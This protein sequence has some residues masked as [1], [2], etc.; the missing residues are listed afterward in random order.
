[1]N[2]NR[3]L[4]LD[5]DSGSGDTVA[6]AAAAAGY[7]TAS[8]R[9]VGQFLQYLQLWQPAFVMLDIGPQTDESMALLRHLWEVRSPALVVLMGRVADQ[10]R[11]H[12]LQHIGASHGLTMAGLMFK[13]LHQSE[14][15]RTLAGLRDDRHWL[16]EAAVMQALD[17]DEFLLEYQPLTD[18]RSG[19]IRS[20]E[21]LIRWR[22]PQRGR[23][24]PDQFIPFVE[25][26]RV[27]GPVTQWVAE[28]AIAQ[29]G[30]WSEM[31]LELNIAINASARNLSDDSLA[32]TILAACERAGIPPERVTLEITETAAM[33]RFEDAVATLSRLR[34]SGMHLAIDDFGTGYSSLAQ[35]RRL[36]FS[37]I[38]I[39]RSLVTNCQQ[40][41]SAL[42]I[43]STVVDLARSL[44]LRCIAEGVETKED[45]DAVGNL[46]CD[47]AQGY[48]ISRPLPA[49]Q[50][51][52]WLADWPVIPGP[53]RSVEL[54]Q[55]IARTA[56][57]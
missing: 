23:I 34:A 8:A 16:T 35:L 14:L 48:L 40:S 38:K 49:D 25:A 18:V 24:G 27:I 39:D 3:L 7:E 50:L 55:N 12:I 26:N 30:A 28:T 37:Q 13:P 11:L 4:I 33:E 46:G 20:L 36:P 6:T 42:Q 10:S 22:H 2:S 29:L 43:I 19:H 45:F 53:R 21:S 17:Q 56:Q 52:P 41:H 54:L 31:G 1:M 47:V 57:A 51:P 32:E 9:S 5:P 15:D 44:G